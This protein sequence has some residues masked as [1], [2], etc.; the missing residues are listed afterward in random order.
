MNYQVS[1]HFSQN[2]S[3]NPHPHFTR[4]QN[5]AEV[6]TTS[7]TYSVQPAIG[8]RRALGFAL[9]MLCFLCWYA[10]LQAG[11]CG[12][13]SCDDDN[14]SIIQFTFVPD[15]LEVAQMALKEAIMRAL[16][17]QD[18]TK[19]GALPGNV[20]SVFPASFLDS[21]DPEVFELG[22]YF[23]FTLHRT[24][25]I[26]VAQLLADMSEMGWVAN[27]YRDQIVQLDR[28]EPQAVA[29]LQKAG[30]WEF[31]SMALPMELVYPA[32]T[33]AYQPTVAV[34]DSGL[35]LA[36]AEFSGATVVAPYNWTKE[37]ATN[38][39]TDFL[40]HG[41]HCSGII[42]ANPGGSERPGVLNWGRV[43]PLKVFDATGKTCLTHIAAA[44][45]HAVANGADVISMSFSLGE[46]VGLLHDTVKVAGRY[47]TLIGSAGNKGQD[48]RVAPAYPAAYDEVVGVTA[49]GC[50]GNTAWFSNTGYE[51]QM[52]GKAINSTVPGRG[53]QFW[54]G[55]SM[56][57]PFAAALTGALK[58]FFPHLSPA[59]LHRVIVLSGGNAERAWDLAKGGLPKTKGT[60]RYTDKEEKPTYEEGELARVLEIRING[61]TLGEGGETTILKEGFHAVEIIF[62]Q[63]MDTRVDPVVA[64]SL[65]GTDE[66]RPVWGRWSSPYV[67]TAK[68]YVG[69][70]I[71]YG[72]QVF[73]VS[74]GRSGFGTRLE[75]YCGEGVET[76]P[77]SPS[78]HAMTTDDETSLD[79]IFME[80]ADCDAYAGAYYYSHPNRVSQGIIGY[81]IYVAS[82]P[83]G[84]FVRFSNQVYRDNNIPYVRYP[85]YQIKFV[86]QSLGE[87]EPVP[88]LFKTFK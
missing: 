60:I 50:D 81:H 23:S 61:R 18:V 24:D 45:G 87:I 46:D 14:K 57:A 49:Y 64:T 21:S 63:E 36:H 22:A 54:S 71:D 70:W 25:G 86:H 39:V 16:E 17:M 68:W 19:P 53:R 43:M 26:D 78:S 69:Y 74:D 4:N 33:P 31:D 40:G 73:W 48:I 62:D 15:S 52:P 67:W 58:G 8:F 35:D 66:K 11:V 30:W 77:D 9:A 65:L 3:T 32:S 1:R 44:I 85:Y 55:T 29:N 59:E 2:L 38:D 34:I 88:H 47:A 56:A 83:E 7:T 80:D 5:S 10:P 41:T 13:F 72:D 20:G 28:A 75:E 12:D 76:R 6:T 42:A 37:G 27:V 79:G 51:T 84:P 82:R